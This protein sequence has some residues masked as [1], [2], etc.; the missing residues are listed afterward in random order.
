MTLLQINIWS[1][2]TDIS[3]GTWLGFVVT[4]TTSFG[5]LHIRRERRKSKLRR[6]LVAEL[7][8]QDLDRVISAVNAS[9]AAVP[10]DGMTDSPDLDAS[11]LPP[12]G[13]LPTQIYTSNAANL[14]ILSEQEV[15]AIVEYYSSL[16][17]QKAIVRTIRSNGG[18]VAA[19]RKE[20]SDTIP[21]LKDD[22]KSLLQALKSEV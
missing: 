11:E 17:T 12:A 2:L 7:E 3:T 1:I 10:P 18:A 6:S 15:A 9:Q 20:L 5:V 22:R 13:I 4:V 19:D 14:G 21:G 8:Q 16:L